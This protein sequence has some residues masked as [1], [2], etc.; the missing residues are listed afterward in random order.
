MQDLSG[1]TIQ[2]NLELLRAKPGTIIP[3]IP[4]TRLFRGTTLIL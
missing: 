1:R 3:L 2:E 4:F